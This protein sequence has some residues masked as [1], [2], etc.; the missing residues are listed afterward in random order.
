MD[1][2]VVLNTVQTIWFALSTIGIGVSVVVFLTNSRE[3]RKQNDFDKFM[4]TENR[5][6]RVQEL[7]LK[8]PSLDMSP[9]RDKSIG[10]LSHVDKYRQSQLADIL[11][12][13]F[14]EVWLLRHSTYKTLWPTW[15]AYMRAYCK[16][17]VFRQL[18][19]EAAEYH[20][21]DFR[22]FL[23]AV[24]RE[25]AHLNPGIPLQIQ[26]RPGGVPA[27]QAAINE[28]DS[29]TDRSQEHLGEPERPKA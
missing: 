19:N 8:Y 7:F 26:P 14:E 13:T 6:L 22:E 24:F 20:L 5:L 18:W 28:P 9:W 27:I 2:V 4:I 15:E 23:N 29:A 3:Q 16:S 12:S 17:D 11:F 25:T 10:D 1:S 21:P